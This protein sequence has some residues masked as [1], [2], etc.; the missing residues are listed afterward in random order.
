MPGGRPRKPDAQRQ[1]HRTLSVVP[2]QAAVARFVVPEPPLTV[3]GEQLA[4]R[5]LLL[6]DRLWLAPVARALDGVDGIDRYVVD[7]WIRAVDRIEHLDRV[8][9][10]TPLVRG[11]KGQPVANPLAAERDEQRRV[12]W[13]AQE[14][15]GLT[16]QDRARLGL[17]IGEV[18]GIARMNEVLDAATRN[19]AFGDE[20]GDETQ[21]RAPATEVS[22]RGGRPR[23]Y[24][25]GAERTAA[26]RA[27][28]QARDGA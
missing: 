13:R 15:L 25:G 14:K 24:A 28:K 12:I 17:V 16:P 3:L 4:V 11:S 21:P 9:Q 18:S 22:S 1:G 2:L 19:E 5:S 7:E 27:R 6:W 20:T 26:Y 8:I 10:E 23:R